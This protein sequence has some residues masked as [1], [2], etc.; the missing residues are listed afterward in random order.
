MRSANKCSRHVFEREIRKRCGIVDLG[1]LDEIFFELSIWILITLIYMCSTYI[2]STYTEPW[3]CFWLWLRYEKTK[4]ISSNSFRILKAAC[5]FNFLSLS[6]SL[7]LCPSYFDSNSIP[8]RSTRS[9]LTIFVLI[10]LLRGIP[11]PRR[12]HWVI[13]CVYL[14]KAISI[15]Q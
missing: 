11:L 4:F 8:V 9:S 1:V 13:D 15:K 10:S 7:S 5:F 12:L 14:K 2:H 3:S 6:L